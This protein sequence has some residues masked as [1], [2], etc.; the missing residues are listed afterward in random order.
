[1]T[2]E[3]NQFIDTDID[4]ISCIPLILSAY[5]TYLLRLYFFTRLSLST[6]RHTLPILLFV[7]IFDGESKTQP[8]KLIYKK[9]N[10]LQSYCAVFLMQSLI[11]VVELKT[12]SIMRLLL[13][14]DDYFC[15]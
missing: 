11:K 2:L 3:L 15:Y 9:F 1:M 12:R 10:I 8:L 6:Y 4:L 5:W 7:R 14:P 13:C